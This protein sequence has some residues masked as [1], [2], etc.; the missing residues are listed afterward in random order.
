MPPLHLVIGFA[1][2][3]EDPV[4]EVGVS[5]A[6]GGLGQGPCQ[7]FY[8]DCSDKSGGDGLAPG[9]SFETEVAVVAPEDPGRYILVFDLLRERLGWFSRRNPEVA[10]EFEVQVETSSPEPTPRAEPSSPRG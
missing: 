9:E 10:R 7:T 5:G 6:L 3:G 2:V 8:L 1:A 4:A